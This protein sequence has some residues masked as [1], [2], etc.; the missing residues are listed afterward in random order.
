MS[1]EE[2]FIGFGSN[3]G[4]RAAMLERAIHEIAGLE[5]VSLLAVS[6]TI[7]TEA[8]LPT[9]HAASQPP[10][11]NRVARYQTRQGAEWWWHQITAIEERMGRV[12]TT[13][14]SSRTIDIDIL[15]FGS[16][17]VSAPDLTIPHPH[18]HERLFVLEPLAAVG[19]EVI[20]PVLGV[21]V[22]A[23]LETF[24]RTRGPR[25]IA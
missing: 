8:L 17:I 21:T 20:H 4:D 19:P 10:Y 16:R 1:V 9:A 2:V 23:L 3:L 22:R 5:G 6:P 13:R 12:R 14:W 25:K 24:D 18:L 7:E 11:L 15:L